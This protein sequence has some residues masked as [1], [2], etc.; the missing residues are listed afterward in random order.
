MVDTTI[1]NIYAQ[2]V[3]LYAG[4]A[5]VHHEVSAWYPVCTIKHS[6]SKNRAKVKQINVEQIEHTSCTCILNAFAGCLL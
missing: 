6:S 1:V 3:A 5:E 4:L 2:L